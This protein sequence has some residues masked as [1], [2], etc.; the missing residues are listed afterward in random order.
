M[1]S[2]TTEM[3]NKFLNFENAINLTSM[4]SDRLS[5]EIRKIYVAKTLLWDIK[6]F[7]DE[8]NNIVLCSF[9]EVFYILDNFFDIKERLEEMNLLRL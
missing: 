6:R 8:F 2:L 3:R 1:V 4:D 9:G 5:D 7:L